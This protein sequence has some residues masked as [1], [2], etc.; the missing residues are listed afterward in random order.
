MNEAIIINNYH[1]WIDNNLYTTYHE[2]ESLCNLVKKKK[3]VSEYI[4]SF[5]SKQVKGI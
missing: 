3:L 1:I 2:T 5:G 4:D